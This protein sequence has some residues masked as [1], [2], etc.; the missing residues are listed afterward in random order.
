[1]E[2]NGSTYKILWEMIS[3]YWGRRLALDWWWVSANQF[4]KKGVSVECS[5]FH[6]TLWGTA[7]KSGFAYLHLRQQDK[8][9]FVMAPFGLASVKGTPENFQ[10]EIKR[11]GKESVTLTCSGSDYGHFGNGII[12]T[13]KGNLKIFLG[14]ELIAQAFGTAALE[15]RAAK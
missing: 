6:T 13:L 1:M 2:N 4:D 14:K 7:I 12:N 3:H 11:I 8:K 5:F 15:H 10:L 9:E